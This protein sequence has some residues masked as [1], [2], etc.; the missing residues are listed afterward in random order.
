MWASVQ[1]S[2]SGVS[3]MLLILLAMSAWM[4][5]R[6]SSGILITLSASAA[7]RE[8]GKNQEERW[9]VAIETNVQEKETV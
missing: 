2:V 4:T 6:V 5:F 3:G 8:R 1:S 9:L 7:L